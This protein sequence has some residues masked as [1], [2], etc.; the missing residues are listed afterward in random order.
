MRTQQLSAVLAFAAGASA[1]Q[2]DFNIE[3]RHTHRK[4]I[5]RRND[6]WP[7]VLTEQETLIANSFDNVTID[8]WSEYYGRQNKLAGFGKEAAEWT[9]DKWASNGF[10]SH[11]NEYHVFLRYP[12]SAALNFT[13]AE[14]NVSEVNLKEDVIEDDEVTG[15]DAISQQTFLGYAPTGHAKA[16]YVY[17]GRGSKADFDALAELGV[18]V[19]GKIALI[20]YGG[21]FRGL[22]V[23]N[24]QDAGALAAVIYLD[25]GDDG[26]V[27]VANGYKAY[28][29]G[30]ARNPH[31]V[32][33]G[34]TLFLSTHPGDPTTPG[35]PS[36]EDAPRADVSDVIA[37][38]PAVPISYSAAEPLLK[39]LN[40]HGIS[41]EQV[42]RTNWIG[43]LDAEYFTGPAPGVTL[44]LDNVSEDVIRPIQ[45]VIGRINGTNHD[46][47]PAKETLFIGN[48]R[49]TWMIGGNGDPNSGSA[50]LIECSKVIKKLID[51]GWKPKRNLVLGSWDAEEWGLI[52]S[53]EYVEEHINE[54]TETLIAYLN[55]DVAVSGPRPDLAAT[56]E[57]H[58]IG[59]EIMKK[60]IHP[61]FGGFNQSLYDSW[62]DASGGVVGVLGSGSDYTAFLHRGISS[63][64]VG[65]GGG[66]TDPIW[67]YHS[68]YDTYHWMATLGDPGF[69][70][71]ASQGQYLALLAYHL[72]DDEILPLDV[73][74]YGVELQAYLDDL[75]EFSAENDA[76]LDFS[77]LEDAIEVFKK[78]AGEAKA[79]EELAVTTNDQ[80]LKDVVNHKYIH[81]QRGF[82]SQG[83]L[84]NREFYRHVVAA[85]GL[86][87]G[88]AAV[89][90]AGATEGIQYAEDGNF[91]VAQEWVSK[92]A[93]GIVV[94]ADI[95]K[96]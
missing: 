14:G 48:H 36:H 42:N 91:N 15:W 40:G 92:I 68:N 75:V 28:P 1:C 66:P 78:R 22:K 10:E 77:E 67:P 65:S 6:V 83:G 53:V 33:K 70:V 81:F 72:L 11:L 80:N 18:D 86:D 45:N 13:D 50:I 26:E 34:S 17:A 19:K 8:E 35:Y 88:Y 4:P 58:T 51:S 93:A 3:A 69:H 30:P 62:Q 46:G 43:G 20:R 60:V 39:A 31:Q 44:E 16:E 41:G 5:L 90:F 27:T 85:P 29:E 23:K 37:K 61:N 25:P 52:G 38:I 9:R 2:R 71:H 96:T 79:L 55:I 7:P 56:P 87:T 76:D 64:D 32:Q 54:L 24:A 95:L 49:D 63:L 57:L 21:L 82:V 47:T 73:V 84:P 59:T 74:N 89:T 94:A 12:V